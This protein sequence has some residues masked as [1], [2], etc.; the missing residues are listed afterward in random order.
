MSSNDT[1]YIDYVSDDSSIQIDESAYAYGSSVASGILH[2]V[3]A[4]AE[5]A[6]DLV[7][8]KLEGMSSLEKISAALGVAQTLMLKLFANTPVGAPI[9][10]A[11]M[12]AKVSVL[13]EAVAAGNVKPSEIL[14]VFA[15]AIS[16]VGA[17]ASLA[18][19][20]SRPARYVVSTPNPS[21]FRLPGSLPLQSGLVRA[22]LFS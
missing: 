6:R 14:G 15:G 12:G 4:S 22:S 10:I 5:S 13:S 9:I 1:D 21:V 7:V 11:G 20:G 8:E 2:D 3:S 17:L 18:V 16:V 19:I